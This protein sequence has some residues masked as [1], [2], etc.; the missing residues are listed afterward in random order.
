M[1][2][3]DLSALDLGMGWTPASWAREAFEIV[4]ATTGL[5]LWGSIILLTVLLRFALLPL[6]IPSMV[7]GAK[8]ANISPEMKEI[9]TRIKAQLTKGDQIAANFEQRSLGLLMRQHDVKLSRSFMYPVAQALTSIACF[10]GFRSMALK[11][12][13]QLLEGGTLWFKDLTVEAHIFGSN[14]V[15]WAPW[16][17]IGVD[18]MW[19]LPMIAT[20]AMWV[21][22]KYGGDIGGPTTMQMQNM[23]SIASGMVILF[24]FVT[25]TQP[26]AVCLYFLTN[27]ILL[28]I[29]SFVLSLRPVRNYF[30]IPDRIVK[31]EELATTPWKWREAPAKFKGWMDNRAKIGIDAATERYAQQMA[32][33]Q[34]RAS[35]QPIKWIDHAESQRLAQQH[36]KNEKKH[37]SAPAEAH[38]QV[39]LLERERLAK[40][41]A[42]IKANR[43]GIKQEG[44]QQRPKGKHMR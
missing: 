6:V 27:N 43:A 23:R 24:C 20:A 44:R 17:W 22:A 15:W 26:Q 25:L 3:G 32:R 39:H 35:H 30:E 2:F 8:L 40:D 5:P 34:R 38:Q 14:I 13:P 29:Q 18:A 7:N 16:T 41:Q 12:V 11:P 10:F 42:A 37:A 36:A 9:Q 31:E 4:A 19:G 21:N 28:L 33:E 1:H